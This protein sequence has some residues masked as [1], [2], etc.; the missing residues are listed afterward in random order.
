[1]DKQ[2][3]AEQFYANQRLES[4]ARQNASQAVRIADLEAQIA[5]MQAQQ[6]QPEPEQQEVPEDVP[7]H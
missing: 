1:M 2:V 3:T 7:Q 4:L 5:L 6:N